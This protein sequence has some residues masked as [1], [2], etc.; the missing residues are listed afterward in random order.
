MAQTKT[1]VTVI[2]GGFAGLAA[3][4]ALDQ[5]GVKLQVVEKRPFFGGRAYSFR[6]PQT[7]ALVDN[8]QHLLM[9][10]YHETFSFLER[11][12]TLDRLNFQAS[13]EVSFAHAAGR[14]ATL[15]CPNWPA[16]LHLGWGLLRYRGLG[17]K[18]K[19]RMNKIIQLAKRTQHNG[20]SWDE[21]SVLQLMQHTGQT[22]EAIKG[23]WEPLGLATLN[24]PLELASAELFLEVLRQGLLKTKEDSRLVIPQ[25][26]FSEL[27]AEPAEEYF[28]DREI[29]LHFQS[30]IEGIEK[31]GNQWL[32]HTR[33]NQPLRTEN[34]L[35]AVPPNALLRILEKS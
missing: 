25:V 31:E 13:L 34:I 18:D 11:L 10:A 8:G 3:A 14:M 22:P 24:E 35:F 26:G 1:Q 4:V 15:K 29:P 2:G 20:K 7:G 9:G 17:L 5:K 12:G 28:R 21:K 23:F 33:G 16:P 27:Y 32:L 19:W 6:E 30:Q